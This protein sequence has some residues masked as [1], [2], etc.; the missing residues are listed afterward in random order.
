MKK[1]VGILVVT[2]LLSVQM[3]QADVI[4]FEVG[5]YQWSPDYSGTLSSDSNGTAGTVIDVKNDLGYSDESHNIL[6]ASL[7]HPIPLLPNIKIVSTDLMASSSSTLTRDLIFGGTTYSVDEDVFS[8]FD[9]SNTEYTLY[10]ELLDN[11]INLDLGITFRKYSGVVKL[12]TDPAGSGLNESEVL[13]FTIPLF[14]ADVRADLPFTGFF[15]DAQA[16]IIGYDN[17]S[18]SDLALTIGYESDFGLG[19]S[20]GYRVFSLE[21]ED[22]TFNSDL[23]FDGAYINVFYHF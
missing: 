23:E 5:A 10:Y 13:D 15:V 16:N 22:D 14:Y 7:E 8:V 2:S 21:V 11:W 4:G 17:D 19:A 6:Y 1:S 3:V 12:E 9:M 18:V 20:V